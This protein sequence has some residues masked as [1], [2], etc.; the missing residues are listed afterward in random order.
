MMKAI[1]TGEK[2]LMLNF[3]FTQKQIEKFMEEGNMTGVNAQ[4]YAQHLWLA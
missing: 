2:W 3:P 4:L 1:Y